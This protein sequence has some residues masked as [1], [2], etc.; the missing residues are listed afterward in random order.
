MKAGRS[1]AAAVTMAL[2][3]VAFAARPHDATHVV[4][5]YAGGGDVPSNLLRVY[6]QLSGPMEPGSAY[7]HIHLIDDGGHEVRDAFLELREE[8]WSPDRRRLTLL[9]DPGRVKRGIRANLEMGAPLRAGHVYRLVID[10]SWRDARNHPLASTFTQELRVAGFDSV[11]PNP[12]RW[13][14]SSPRAGTRDPLLVQFGEALDHALAARLIVVVDGAGAIVSGR[15]SLGAGDR[16][17]TFVPDKAWPVRAALR[18]DP[19]LEDLAGNNIVRRFDTDREHAG[20][21]LDAAVTDTSARL[22][23]VAVRR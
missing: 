18:V 8:L 10:S 2:A 13:S 7:E 6:V 12:S 16:S 23:P 21:A 22:I 9:F 19:A 4:A 20:R 1:I 17:W 14:L 5:V 11:S 3:M 15:G